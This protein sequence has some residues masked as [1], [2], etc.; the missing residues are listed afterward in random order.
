MPKLSKEEH[1]LPEGH[2]LSVLFDET[3]MPG[4]G[5]ACFS[6]SDGSLF[7]FPF[8]D[9]S[10]TAAAR[11]SKL[12]FFWFKDLANVQALWLH[13]LPFT[14][15]IAQRG[16]SP[17]NTTYYD[18]YYCGQGPFASAAALL[19]TGSSTGRG[20]DKGRGTGRDEQ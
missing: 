15:H 18:L 2:P 11:V 1:V 12:Q 19:A 5:E 6:A 8:N 10:A 16:S 20:R 4:C 3:L 14:M 13:G 9:I 17:A 7:P